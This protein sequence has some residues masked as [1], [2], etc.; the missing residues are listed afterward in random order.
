L[1]YH[2]LRESPLQTPA[3]RR[4]SERLQILCSFRQMAWVLFG[5][6]FLRALLSLLAYPP[7]HGAD[8]L[9]YFFYAERLNG[10]DISNLS[11]VVPPLYSA[12]ILVSYKW[13]GSIYWL[14]G[15][16]FVMSAALAPLYY[17]ALKPYQ[18]VFALLSALVILLDFQTATPFNFIS[19]EPLYIWLLAVTFYLFMRQ[20]QKTPPQGWLLADTLPGLSL[21]LL[22]LTRAVGRFLIVPLA[23]IFWLRTRHWKRTLVFIGGFVAYLMIYSLLSQIWLGGVEGSTSSDYMVTGVVLRNKDW[24]TPENGP[25]SAEFIEMNERCTELGL[26]FY[27][28]YYTVRGS[29]DGMIGLV[30]NTTLES[31]TANWWPYV[32]GIWQRTN[33]FLSLSGQ[34]VGIDPGLPSEVQCQMTDAQ[35]DALTPESTLGRGWGWTWGIRDYISLNFE[36]FRERYRQMRMALCP[37][38]SGSSMAKD[39]VDYLMFRY[40]SLGRP[41]PYLYY[42]LLTLLVFVPRWARRYWVV[43]LTAGALLLYHALISAV[44]N[45]VQP[46]YVMVTNPFRAILLTLLVFLIFRI[47]IWGVD[48]LLSRHILAN[49]VDDSE[50]L[51]S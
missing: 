15:A 23:A 20:L 31:V 18:P 24:L 44:I 1:L 11:Q 39:V 2:L 16:Q 10:L 41:Q 25:A 46:R 48:W 37:P 30:I 17:L 42:G 40:R 34:Q 33:A 50:A 38:L 27:D 36:D 12:L 49:R 4:L 51:S 14:V 28:C 43:L 3:L 13:L 35:I 47:V 5:L 19:T 45:N 6:G 29:W 22:M 9:A 32:E 7:A 8:S 26:R 21:L